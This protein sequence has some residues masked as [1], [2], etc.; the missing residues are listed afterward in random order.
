MIINLFHVI[1]VVK[2][3]E[4]SSVKK[5]KILTY[6][7]REYICLDWIMIR[8]DEFQENYRA[9]YNRKGVF[10]LLIIANKKIFLY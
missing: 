10:P 5:E 3:I 6:D 1:A 9:K 4:I 8:T 7:S 2:W